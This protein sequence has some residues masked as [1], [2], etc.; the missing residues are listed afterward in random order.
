[1][2]IFF[3]CAMTYHSRLLW[4][5]GGGHSFCSSSLL[6]LS[7]FLQFFLT[8]LAV[9][10]SAIQAY[11]SCSLTHSA[12]QQRMSVVFIKFYLCGLLY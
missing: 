9:Q 11:G 3:F 6:Y 10:A 12:P 5:L 8:A 4:F 7:Q 2:C 1:M